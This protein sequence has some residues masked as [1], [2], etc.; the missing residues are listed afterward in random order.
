L[1]TPDAD[2]CSPNVLGNIHR[3]ASQS[4]DAIAAENRELFVPIDKDSLGGERPYIGGE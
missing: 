1:I 2:I 3:L 4:P